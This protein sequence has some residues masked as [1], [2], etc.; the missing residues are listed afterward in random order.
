MHATPVP[1]TVLPRPTL[2][3]IEQNHKLQILL[4]TF[5]T[6][7]PTNLPISGQ[8]VGATYLSRRHETLI[9]PLADHHKSCTLTFLQK[10]NA[11]CTPS[12]DWLKQSLRFLCCSS[13]NLLGSLFSGRI[14]NSPA[15]LRSVNLYCVLQEDGAPIFPQIGHLKSLCRSSPI[16]D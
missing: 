10:Q 6:T 8:S 5:L 7:P 15:P 14:K 12:G 3:I 11:W 1:P 9:C 2:H 13:W 16:S 4:F